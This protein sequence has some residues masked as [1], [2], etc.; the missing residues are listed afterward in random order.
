MQ[1]KKAN[2]SYPKVKNLVLLPFWFLLL[3]DLCS[4][5]NLTESSLSVSSEKNV[6]VTNISDLVKKAPTNSTVYLKGNVG[7]RAPFLG[8]GAY[9]VLD[10]TGSIWVVTKQTLPKTGDLVLI[11]GKVQY[12]SIPLIFA[13]GGKDLGEVYVQESELLKKTPDVQKLPL[14]P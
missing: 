13:A 10:K 1:A 5:G 14:V 7:S 4:C 11:K 12:E 9:E 6:T 8:S 3:G 2:G